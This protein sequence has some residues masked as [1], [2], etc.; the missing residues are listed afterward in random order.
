MSLDIDCTEARM[1]HYLGLA[2]RGSNS[3]PISAKLDML[4]DVV[5]SQVSAFGSGEEISLKYAMRAAC[6]G[7]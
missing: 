6:N 5:V 7:E 3:D 4:H 1:A 2:L